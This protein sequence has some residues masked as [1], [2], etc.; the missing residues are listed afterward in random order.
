MSLGTLSTTRRLFISI[1]NCSLWS[2]SGSAAP[3]TASSE[4]G[5]PPCTVAGSWFRYLRSSHFV[6]TSKPWPCSAVNSSSPNTCRY[7]ST[8]VGTPSMRSSSSARRTRATAAWRSC[9]VTMSLPIIESNFGEIVSPSTTPE[10]TRTPG[11]AGHCTRSSV[12]E[13]G[14]RFVFGSSLV[15]RSS[16]LWPRA[17]GSGETVP[18]AA[19][20]NCSRTKSSPLTSSLTVCSTCRRGFTSISTPCPHR[21]P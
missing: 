16:K 9:A 4:A 10:S 17:V 19:I 5:W 8:G 15:M 1:T 18:P 13:L 11:P 3:A 14:V 20:C 21:S 12:P 7:S 2:S 6:L